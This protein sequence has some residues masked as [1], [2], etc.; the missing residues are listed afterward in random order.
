[1]FVSHDQDF[2]NKLATD[3]VE[4]SVDGAKEYQGNYE[5]YLYQK[6]QEAQ[7]NQQLDVPAS[8]KVNNKKEEVIAPKKVMLSSSEIKALERTIQKL[9]HEIS[10]TENSF[11]DLTF[12]S[13]KFNDAQKKL[14]DLKKE[15]EVTLAEWESSQS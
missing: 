7:K 13:A 2:V 9:E 6:Q 12:G 14:T 10:R 8:K 3:I 11:A 15:L 5:L 1:L 4:L